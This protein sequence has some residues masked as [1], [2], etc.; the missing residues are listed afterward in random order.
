MSE[1]VA[2]SKGTGT[3]STIFP[4]VP[5]EF[6]SRVAGT[7]EADGFIPVDGEADLTSDGVG[8]PGVR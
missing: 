7:F 5:G 3:C 6:A 8:E 1:M 2:K 4:S